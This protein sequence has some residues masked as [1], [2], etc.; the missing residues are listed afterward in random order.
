MH[1]TRS[2]QRLW[3][4]ALLALGAATLLALPVVLLSPPAA[5]AKPLQTVAQVDLSQ[6]T[7]TWYEIASFPTSFQREDCVG[8]T[9]NYTANPDGTIKVFNSCYYPE[10]NSWKMDKAEGRAR[11]VDP[12][13]NAKLKV[14]FFW[15]FEGDYWVIDLDDNYQYAVVGHPDRNYLWILSRTPKMD[16]ATYQ[17]IL[18][19]LRTQ[20]YDVARLRRTQTLQDAQTASVP[21]SVR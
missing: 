14:Q 3:K 11:V 8:T 6:Y 12:Q 20:E 16:E 15:P 9:A 13:T 19:R 1:H 10:G 7:G 21:G 18:A 5:Q 17:E 4:P 2:L